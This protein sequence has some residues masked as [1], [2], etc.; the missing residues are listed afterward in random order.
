MKNIQGALCMFN[1]DYFT[2]NINEMPHM[3]YSRKVEKQLEKMLCMV[4]YTYINSPSKCSPYGYVDSV[5]EFIKA[6]NI[7]ITKDKINRMYTKYTMLKNGKEILFFM[8]KRNE[9]LEGCNCKITISF[10]DIQSV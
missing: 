2:N 4:G 6:N 5:S 1:A 9:V 3:D 7:T 10:S 8:E